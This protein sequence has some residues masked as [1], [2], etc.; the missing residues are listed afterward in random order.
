MKAIVKM[1][2][3]EAEGYTV[4]TLLPATWLSKWGHG[5]RAIV[6]SEGLY[7]AWGSAI[8]AT[9]RRRECTLRTLEEAEEYM[10]KVI[11]QIYEALALF[12]Q[13]R[14]VKAQEINL[15]D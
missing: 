2:G 4:Q 11:A 1:Y 14:V 12:R 7:N 5:R 15:D 9:Y 3:S 8:D 13:G 10:K 6:E